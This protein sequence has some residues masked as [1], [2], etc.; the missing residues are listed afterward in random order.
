MLWSSQLLSDGVC[1]NAPILGSIDHCSLPEPCCL[2]GVGSTL[3]SR[4]ENSKP[5]KVLPRLP[6]NSF[7]SLT[8]HASGSH[9][10][11]CHQ[12]LPF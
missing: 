8:V 1:L 6:R 7:T 5:H 10:F 4:L 9:L 12:T 2:P 3:R 11:P